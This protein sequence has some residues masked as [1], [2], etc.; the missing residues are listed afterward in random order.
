[1]TNDDRSSPALTAEEC[2]DESSLQRF[3]EERI[4]VNAWP[5]HARGL[6]KLILRKGI[7]L[8]EAR[9]FTM[10][11]SDMEDMMRRLYRR[12]LRVERILGIDNAFHTSLHN[13]EVLLRLLLLEWPCGHSLPEDVRRAPLKVYRSME[14]I[15]AVTLNVIRELVE[16]GVHPSIIARDMLAAL[17]H[18]FG[19]SGGTDRVDRHGVPAPL[20]HEEAAEKHVAKIGV[21][22]GFPPALILES[23]AGIRATTFYSRP[24]RKRVQAANDFERRLAL[25]DVM[26]CVLPPDLWLTHVGVPVLLEKIPTWKR[27]LTRISGDIERV[28]GELQRM[29]AADVRRKEKEE[30]YK[31]LLAEDGRIIRDIEEW[32]RSERGFFLFIEAHKLD[33]VSGARE[34]W[35]DILKDK[36]A[37]MEEVL[38]RKDLLEPLAARGF[39]F[40]EEYAASLANTLSLREWLKREDVDPL[41]REIL[42]PFLRRD[43][44]EVV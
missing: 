28:K 40:L 44:G 14:S 29:P 35:G 31:E 3:V 25:A 12:S 4:S 22:L 15:T 32:F 30:E 19:H 16:N 37:L 5:I 8:V 34:L 26:G 23:M 36:I 13:F 21:E 42:S 20:T 33:P 43:A 38:E 7:D 10:S 27:R 1:M 41:L 17:G 18:D 2:R 39:P 6:R 11:L 9:L 24:G